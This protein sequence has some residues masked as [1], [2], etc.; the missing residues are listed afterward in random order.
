LLVDVMMLPACYLPQVEA[1]WG[2]SLR[3]E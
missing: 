3:W 2:L 1:G